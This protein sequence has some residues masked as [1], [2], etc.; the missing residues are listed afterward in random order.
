VQGEL[1][2]ALLEQSSMLP[3]P[4]LSLSLFLLPD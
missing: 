3:P 4:L 1:L 2:W